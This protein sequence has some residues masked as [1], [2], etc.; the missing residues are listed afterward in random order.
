MAG[1]LLASTALLAILLTM[2]VAPLSSAVRPVS[3]VH[4]SAAAELFA[5]YADGSFGE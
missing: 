1:R 3:D 5:P 4:R 2:A